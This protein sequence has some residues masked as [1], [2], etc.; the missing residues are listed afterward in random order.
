MANGCGMEITYQNNDILTLKNAH[1]IRCKKDEG[2]R[3]WILQQI[4]DD[5]RCLQH[6]KGHLYTTLHELQKVFSSHIT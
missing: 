1:Q 3:G 6:K 2:N 5:R 4:S